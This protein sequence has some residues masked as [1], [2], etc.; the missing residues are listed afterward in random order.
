MLTSI[1][2]IHQNF[3]PA[4]H[5]LKGSRQNIYNLDAVPT[6]RLEALLL[7]YISKCKQNAQKHFLLWA[8]AQKK[9]ETENIHS[10]DAVVS[11][12][13]CSAKNKSVI[14]C[15]IQKKIPGQIFFLSNP[16]S[17]L[18]ELFIFLVELWIQFLHHCSSEKIQKRQNK[19]EKIKSSR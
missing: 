18:R 8:L 2:K 14:N 19:L 11:Q 7:K 5:L 13:C 10:P 3:S 17:V 9:Q 4:G 12:I 1:Y 15:Q 6:V 16:P